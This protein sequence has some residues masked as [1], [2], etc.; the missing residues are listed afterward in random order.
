MKIVQSYWSRPALGQAVEGGRRKGGWASL[1]Y[2]CLGM[3]L[4]CL[5]LRRMYDQVE[6]V[7]DEQGKALLIDCLQLPY[8]SVQVRLNE[9]DHYPHSLWALPKLFAY[10]L[11]QEPF[12]HVDSDFFA[13][14]PFGPAIEN[15]PL[16]AQSPELD[17]NGVYDRSLQKL[18]RT[19]PQLPAVLAECHTE[20]GQTLA[21]NAG[22]LGGNDLAF[23]QQY[24]REAFAL[25]DA[26][27]DAFR[28][29]EQAGLHNIIIEQ[30][31]FYQLAVKQQ[32]SIAYAIPKLS[33]DFIELIKLDQVPS[34]SPYVHLI[35]GAKSFAINCEQIEQRLHYE[36]PREYRRLCRAIDRLPAAEPAAPWP[37]PVPEAEYP[38][39]EQFLQHH[40]HSAQ[41]HPDAELRR[42]VRQLTRPLTPAAATFI[43]ELFEVERVR[44][45][46]L[47]HRRSFAGRRHRYLSQ[48]YDFMIGKDAQ[49]IMEAS[50]TLTTDA[51]IVP[52]H[53][54]AELFTAA[55]LPDLAQ[56]TLPDSTR[57]LLI[58]NNQ[59]ELYTK[60]LFG[61]D[62][63]LAFFQG[64]E[65]SGTE[66]MSCF[67][68]AS[69]TA[70]EREQMQLFLLDFL[71]YQLVY[72]GRLR[73]VVP[74]AVPVAPAAPEQAAVLA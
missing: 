35:G 33:P 27:L 61:L 71:T 21:V 70:T 53:W 12:I 4:S 68:D 72:G 26:N 39:L 3:A 30:Y 66:I 10:G 24:V 54:A 65:C 55:E 67:L 17:F 23:I 37:T 47:R 15:S 19:L 41:A 2:Q 50:Y 6:L 73:P 32:K 48:A 38:L 22:I 64:A 52:T 49:A 36:F 57:Y 9:L 11:Q 5:L 46:M 40:G 62:Q 25:V 31:T 60:N 34:I 14:Q 74:A 20:P 8:T 69:S 1:R 63:P 42:L 29:D 16:I 7:T 43:R 13:W 58:G 56:L 51:R 28:Q 44:K 59:S 18:A 45:L